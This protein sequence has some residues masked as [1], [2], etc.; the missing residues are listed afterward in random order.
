MHVNTAKSPFQRDEAYFSEETFFGEFAKETLGVPLSEWE[1]LDEQKLQSDEKAS[2]T[3]NPP[4][5]SNK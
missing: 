3:A 2:T 1:D 5:H 4:R